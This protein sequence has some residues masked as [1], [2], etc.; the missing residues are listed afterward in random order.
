MLHRKHHAVFEKATEEVRREV[1]RPKCAQIEGS[2][3][4]HAPG[5]PLLHILAE[6]HLLPQ[7]HRSIPTR[8]RVTPALAA[9]L[10]LFMEAAMEVILSLFL[11]S[12][13]NHHLSLSQSML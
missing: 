7:A 5:R 10:D 12:C 13:R 1:A 8:L 3:R 11:E 4:V 9:T 2:V 6:H